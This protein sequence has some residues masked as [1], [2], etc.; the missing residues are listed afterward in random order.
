MSN[1]TEKP[2]QK[3]LQDS[4][5][6]GQTFKCRDA[7]IACMLLCGI[8]WLTSMS[9]LNELMHNYHN[10]IAGNFE[11]DIKAYSLAMMI[12]ALKVI[13]PILLICVLTSALPSLLQTGFIMATKALKFDFNALNPTKGIKKIFS[14]RT[15]KDAIKACLY[16]ASFAVATY[17]TWHN[18]KALVFSQLYGNLPSIANIWRELLL[19]LVITCLACLLIVSLLDALADYFL[20]MK[21]LKMD[22]QE[23]K[24]EMKEQDGNPEIKSKRRHLHMEMLSEQTKSD[25]RSSRV[26]IANPTH[27]AI[28]I[29]FSSK[30]TPTPF[31]SV[32][33]ANERA[34]AVR[35][36]AEEVGVPVV[37]DIKLARKLFKNHKLYSY[38]RLDEL[39]DVVDLLIWLRDVEKNWVHDDPDT[40]IK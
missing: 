19:S 7:I 35:R 20:H 22:K 36:Y 28:G 24:R 8:F 29:Y 13:L 27:I 15:I 32:K 31:I 34:L 3:R 1:K 9:S 39:N 26:I 10:F 17:I 40:E 23:V 14:L 16:L 2:T 37:R 4:A 25:I 30:I 21:D 6:K 11:M 12:L 18:H 33:E 38:V 5:E